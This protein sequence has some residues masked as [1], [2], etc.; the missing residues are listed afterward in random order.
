M[1]VRASASIP[2]SCSGAMYWKV[3]SRVPLPVIGSSAVGI[4]A[5]SER[6]S[7]G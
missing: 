4:A 3:P 5:S 2:S 1:S 7:G 6:E